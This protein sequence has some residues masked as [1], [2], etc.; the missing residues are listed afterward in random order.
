[1]VL[2]KP[3]KAISLNHKLSCKT[4]E[5]LVKLNSLIYTELIINVYF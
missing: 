4:I 5:E 1:M 3:I 2:E